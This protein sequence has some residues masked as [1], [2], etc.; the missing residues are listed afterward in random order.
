[1]DYSSPWSLALLFILF[2]STLFF[3]GDRIERTWR[4]RAA[5]PFP[6][7]VTSHNGTA[8]SALAT[9]HA[10]VI[11]ASPALTGMMTNFGG[12][13]SPR[14]S[15]L[16]AFLMAFMLVDAVAMG[17]AGD[18]DRGRWL[19]HLLGFVGA[20]GALF[21]GASAAEALWS[22]AI[23]EASL[24]FYLRGLVVSL[25][26]RGGPWDRRAQLGFSVVFL[27]ARLL[28]MPILLVL[29]LRS[30]DSLLVVKVVGVGLTGL[31]VY[32]S[33]GVLTAGAKSQWQDA[34]EPKEAAPPNDPTL[35]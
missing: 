34:S 11:V 13:N 24:C 26:G 12:V 20:A 9:F 10:V 3:I 2:W 35:S 23:A 15:M 7:R 6:E 28:L 17:V 25:D 21:S 4:L 27:V 5:R 8:G 32:W 1:L 16:V 18:K 19:H 22:A 33:W 31:G 30:P 14:Q 29:V